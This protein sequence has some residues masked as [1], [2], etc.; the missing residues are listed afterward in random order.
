[1][2]KTFILG[3]KSGVLVLGLAAFS[4]AHTA[5]A[6]AASDMASSANAA[7][8]GA[9][10]E[11]QPITPQQWQNMTPE[12]KEQLREKAK[13]QW[14]SMTPEQREA[15]KKKIEAFRQQQWEQM[16]PEQKK[17][18]KEKMKKMWESLNP[19]QQQELMD[20]AQRRWQAMSPAM[21]EK[22]MNAVQQP[23]NQ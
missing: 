15:L 22:M 3:L 21:K 4:Y 18:M 17:E 20:M 11:M 2:K 1:M 7:V 12:Q 8:S 16:S 6:Q 14:E 23:A 10:H 9:G 13:K 19:V 5:N